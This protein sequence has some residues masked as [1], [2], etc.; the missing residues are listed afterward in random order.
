MRLP[1]V[2]RLAEENNYY[3]N[4]TRGDMDLRRMAQDLESSMVGLSPNEER[5]LDAV[6]AHYDPILQEKGG[7][8]AVMGEFKT[9]LQAQ[10]ETSLATIS[11]PVADHPDTLEEIKLPF[12]WQALQALATQLTPEQYQDA[13]KAY[14]AH[15][16]HTAYRYLSKPNHWMHPEAS[17]VCVNPYNPEERWSTFEDYLSI[18]APFYLATFDEDTPALE[19]HT[20]ESRK[21]FF[22]KELALIGRA[23]NWD[24]RNQEGQEYDDRDADKPSCFSGVKRRLWQAVLGHPMFQQ[25]TDTALQL[26]LIGFTHRHFQQCITP[27][28]MEAVRGAFYR[29]IG[30]EEYET[31]DDSATNAPTEAS[32]LALLSSLNIEEA[33]LQALHDSL[34]KKYDGLLTRNSEFA[35]QFTSFFELN[36]K[37]QGLHVLLPLGDSIRLILEALKPPSE[38]YFKDDGSQEKSVGPGDAGFFASHQSEEGS[39]EL[40]RSAEDLDALD[41]PGPKRLRHG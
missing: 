31:N 28:N 11:T 24:E 1:D 19:G 35:A 18:I 13:L 41:R 34:D 7:I 22:V 25:L 26:E 40:K 15:D 2:Q 4:Q 30:Y 9:W 3:Q 10:Y 12:E 20:L 8:D 6:Q 37:N 32:D 23:H 21:G 5:L 36:V 17:N 39:S 14:Y 38:G 16:T 27:E 33:R 29:V